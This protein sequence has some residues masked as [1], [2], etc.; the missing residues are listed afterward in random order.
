MREFTL[1][2]IEIHSAAVYKEQTGIDTIPP[3]QV[4]LYVVY[5]YWA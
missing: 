5:R 1:E 4:Q 2:Q 3:S